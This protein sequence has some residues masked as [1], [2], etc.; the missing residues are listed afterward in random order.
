MTPSSQLRLDNLLGHC[1]HLGISGI[2]FSD[3]SGQ[4]THVV[5]KLYCTEYVPEDR[6]VDNRE[7]NIVYF[8][9]ML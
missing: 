1:C 9:Q 7:N 2:S 4:H 3:M 6:F 5:F 8:G